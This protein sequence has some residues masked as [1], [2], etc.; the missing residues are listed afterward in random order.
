MA[1]NLYRAFLDLLPARP[2]QIGQVSAVDGEVA[3]VTLAGGGV[4]TARGAATVGQSV[5]VHDGAI[6]GEA[7]DMPVVLVEV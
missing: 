4:L 2:W 5:F 6:V 1:H 7:P 3:T